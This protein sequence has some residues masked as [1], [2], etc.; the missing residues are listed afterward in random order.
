M[1]LNVAL[2]ALPSIS[3]SQKQWWVDCHISSTDHFEWKFPFSFVISSKPWWILWFPSSFEF[4][5]AKLNSYYKWLLAPIQ[6]ARQHFILQR[7][8]VKPVHSASSAVSFRC[9]E[10]TRGHQSWQL[11]WQGSS[12]PQSAPK[13]IRH[14]TNHISLS[15]KIWSNLGYLRR[16]LYFPTGIS[17]QKEDSL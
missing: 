8:P 1:S 14:I 10:D 9:I 13:L 2:Y 6:T 4:Q 12:L 16:Y 11:N 15:S 5:T 17:A 7:W 3:V